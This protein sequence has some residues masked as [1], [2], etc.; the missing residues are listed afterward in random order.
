MKP[1]LLD[2]ALRLAPDDELKAIQAEL[3]R[4]SGTPADGTELLRR[5][6]LWRRHDDLVA[7]RAGSA[8]TDDSGSKPVEPPHKPFE[9]QCEVCGKW[10][11]FGYG[12]GLPRGKPG[13]WYCREHRPDA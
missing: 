11:A 12:V 5:Q 4:V 13:I 3:R 10:G 8:M 6:S 1:E 9:H 7:A 2:R